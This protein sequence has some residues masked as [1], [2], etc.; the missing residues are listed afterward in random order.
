MSR[1]G[2]F[3]TKRCLH[4]W[5]RPGYGFRTALLLHPGTAMRCL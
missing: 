4:Q 3:P 5:S 1:D 2:E